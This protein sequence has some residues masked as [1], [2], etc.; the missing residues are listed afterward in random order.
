M[1][2]SSATYDIISYRKDYYKKHRDYIL[3]KNAQWYKEH[4]EH[5]TKR[6]TAN[7]H[8][9][10]ISWGKIIPKEATCGI[11]YSKIYFHR[12]DAAKSIHFDHRHNGEEPIKH[13]SM[14]LSSHARTK[15][16]E[17]LWHS[18]DFG[19][20]CNTCNK[21]LPTKNR[22]DYL[23]RIMMYALTEG[24]VYALFKEYKNRKRKK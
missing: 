12:R 17:T 6:V 23:L 15:E 24:E 16:N 3:S 19:M 5:N 13:P 2:K 22:V 20:L 7:V 11:C 18:C 21:M 9:R 4:K 10:L 14:W 1:Q 8:K